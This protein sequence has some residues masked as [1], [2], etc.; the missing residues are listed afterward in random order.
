VSP[1]TTLG[2]GALAL[3][4]GMVVAVFA[5]VPDRHSRD[6]R[7]SLATADRAVRMAV[8]SA[9]RNALADGA[10]ELPPPPPEPF[11]D[12]VLAP[13]ADRLSALGRLLTP[14]GMSAGLQRRLDYA[15]NPMA[16]PV[17]RIMI[18][19]GLLAVAGAV[20]GAL[21]GSMYGGAVGVVL[22][23][24]LGSVAGL[25]LPDILIANLG[26]RRQ[27]EIRRTL[28]DVLDVLTVSVEAGLGFDAALAQVVTN[29]RGPMVGE[30]ARLLYEM[31]MGKPRSEALRAMAGRTKVVE[32]RMFAQA[33]VQSS[34]LGIPVGTVLREQSKEMRL[35]RRQLAEEKAQKVPVKILFPML[36]LM[37][38][39]LFV[40]VI[41]P[42]ALRMLE[43]FSR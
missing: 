19:K 35:R 31:Q 9:N 43:L 13:F 11:A 5:A 36:F 12:R 7:R 32:L 24:P 25:L 23:A 3:F 41:G 10:G 14:A 39:A 17:E 37:F 40:V 20:L 26:Q 18:A 21:V 4:A 6:L 16:W 27:H 22:G 42:G 28:A 30:I 15:G 38:P 2:V 29:G 34:E 8:H 1:E 33:V